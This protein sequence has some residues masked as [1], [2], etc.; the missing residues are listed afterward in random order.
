[1]IDSTDR[2]TEL[3]IMEVVRERF[4]DHLVLGEEGGVSGDPTSEYL[5]CIDPLGMSHAANCYHPFV[6]SEYYQSFSI[7]FFWMR[8]W[9]EGWMFILVNGTS[10]EGIALTSWGTSMSSWYCTSA[11]YVTMY[12]KLYVTNSAGSVF[13]H[14]VMLLNL[15]MF[16]SWLQMA[17]R[18]LLMVILALLSL[19]LCFIEG[20]LSLLRWWVVLWCGPI[21]PAQVFGVVML[22]KNH[23]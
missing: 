10:G 19:L 9:F 3:A 16:I 14:T 22:E 20:G 17:Q 21:L 18:I 23:A 15:Y 13:R 4:P 6:L 7:N 5:W 11:Q 1:M 8:I 2:N 12:I